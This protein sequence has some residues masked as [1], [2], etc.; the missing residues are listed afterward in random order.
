MNLERIDKSLF[1]RNTGAEF[2]S[3]KGG[4]FKALAIKSLMKVQQDI[5]LKQYEN[6]ELAHKLKGVVSAL[7][8]SSAADVCKKIEHYEGM[9]NDDKVKDILL[10]ITRLMIEE[11]S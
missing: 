9:M 2:E 10:K 8:A 5:L 7:G 4:F 11:L 1:L 6:K 3:D